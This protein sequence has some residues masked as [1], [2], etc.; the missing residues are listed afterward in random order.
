MSRR[1]APPRASALVESLRG[2][3][4]STATAVADV[5]DNSIAAGARRVDVLFDWRAA[6]SWI[7]IVDDGR[8]MSPEQLDSAMRLGARNPL[9]E[10]DPGDLGRF[11][12]GLKTAAFSQGRRLTVA[13]R[14]RGFDVDCLRW[15]LDRLADPGDEGWHLLEGAHPGSEQRLSRLDASQT[16][17]M[18]L[19]ERL[20]RLVTPGFGPDDFIEVVD[21]VE[22][23]LAMVFHRWIEG[24]SPRL[25][26][27]LNGSPVRPWDPF[28]S[29]HPSKPWVQP[30][31]RLVGAGSVIV[32]AHVLPHKDKLTDREYEDAAGPNGWNGQQGFYLYRNQRLI[33]AGGWLGLGPGRHWTRDEP[34]RLARIRLDITNEAD[35]EWKLDVRKSTA[36]PPVG[37]RRPLTRIAEEARDRARRTF[38]HRGGMSSSRSGSQPVEPAWR[39]TT[40]PEGVRYRISRQHEAVMALFERSPDMRP[41]LE[42]TLRLIEETVPVQRIWL[43]TA[44]NRD[45]PSVG[46]A[47]GAEAEVSKVLRV[48]FRSLVERRGLSVEEARL[49][50]SRTEPFD[51][52]PALVAALGFE[53]KA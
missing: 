29:G 47:Q 11:G 4:Y 25:R 20:D 50:L 7:G 51:A 27:F 32:E 40:T 33:V 34:H 1:A 45:L 31:V 8:G 48:M 49:R 19:F 22:R 12:L 23:H 36:R 28:M 37:L 14:A 9:D 52:H 44:E 42:A 46:F 35:A 13:S 43:D 17:T 26:I 3:G 41:E 24:G 53:E 6:D 5:V 18:V 38:A 39:A 30:E 21:G 16:G 2:L 15:D 10:R